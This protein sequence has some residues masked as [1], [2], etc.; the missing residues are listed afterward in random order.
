MEYGDK[1]MTTDTVK[2]NS[3]MIIYDN[4]SH[5]LGDDPI[6][7]DNSNLPFTFHL[8]TLA[9]YEKKGPFEQ[10]SY[11]LTGMVMKI[12]RKSYGK[13]LSGYFYPMAAFAVL[14]MISFLIKPDMVRRKIEN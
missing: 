14:S 2:Y 1:T 11:S 4:M 8:H 7:I 10:S 12:C 13:L 3:S 5:S 9:A 6:I